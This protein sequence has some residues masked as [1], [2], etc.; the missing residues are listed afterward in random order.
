MPFSD[1]VRILDSMRASALRGGRRWLAVATLLGV[2]G[3]L[4]A[5]APRPAKADDDW[6]VTKDPFNLTIVNRYKALLF[7]NPEENRNVEAHYNRRE[8]AEVLLFSE[9]DFAP[10]TAPVAPTRARRARA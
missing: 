8:D 6:S 3:T 1:L 4:T 5:V 10:P 9:P 7:K 2:A